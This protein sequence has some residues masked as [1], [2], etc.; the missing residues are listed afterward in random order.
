MNKRE[1]VLIASRAVSLYLIFWALDN[2]SYVPVDAFSLSH[3]SSLPASAGQNYLYKYHLVL[4]SHHLVLS[5]VFFVGAV[6]LYRCGPSVESFL[7]A[8]DR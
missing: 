1:L 8:T 6:W 2:F 7:S 5:V 3:Y 4:L